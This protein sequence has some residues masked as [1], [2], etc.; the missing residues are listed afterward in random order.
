MV[1]HNRCNAL[2]ITMPRVR[3]AVFVENGRKDLTY[4]FP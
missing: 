2:S 3:R 1:D 4:E